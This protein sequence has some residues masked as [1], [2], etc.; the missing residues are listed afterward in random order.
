MIAHVAIFIWM[1]S[2]PFFRS[3]TEEGYVENV[4]F[5]GVGEGCLG[6]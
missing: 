3:A 1:L 5:G 6:T 2:A 4:G